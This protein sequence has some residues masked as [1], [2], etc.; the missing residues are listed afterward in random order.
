MAFSTAT[1]NSDIG[2]VKISSGDILAGY[3]IDKLKAGSGITLTK[4]NTGANEDILITSTGGAG[5]NIEDVSSQANG[6][7]TVFLTTNTP[8]A[9]IINHF[10]YIDGYGISI[11]G[12]Q[13]TIVD[14]N[15]IPQAGG[16]VFSVY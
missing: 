10:L 6:S 1:Y 8:R 2:K 7:N 16:E 11:T 15:L 12:N 14:V 4:E 13:F 9:V 5:F 3:L